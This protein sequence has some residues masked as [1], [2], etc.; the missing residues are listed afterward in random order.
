MRQVILTALVLSTVFQFLII[1]ANGQ[2]N[3]RSTYYEQRRTLFENLPNDKREIIF[4]GNSITDGGEWTELF[5]NK[6]IKNRGISGDTTEGVLFRLN[7]VTGSRPSKIFLLIGINDLARGITKETVFDNICRIVREIENQS[8]KTSIYLQSILPVN[9]EFGKFERHCSKT[10]DIIW[11]NRKLHDFCSQSTCNYVDLFSGF[12]N[13][14]NNY[15][16]PAY[17]NDGLHLTGRGYL[18][19]S[20][21]VGPLL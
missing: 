6:R 19:W 7:E 10:E 21:I 4:L 18:A 12:K 8:P 15:M 2:E 13:T 16:N 9:P 20:E 1:S 5:N 14:E 11:M 17:T 3:F